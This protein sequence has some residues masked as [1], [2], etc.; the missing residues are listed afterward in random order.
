MKRLEEAY[1]DG[2]D[3]LN[4]LS[5]ET[6]ESC[7]TFLHIQKCIASS[8]DAI[9]DIVKHF[10]MTLE[11]LGKQIQRLRYEK[12]ILE[13][14]LPDYSGPVV[15]Q[16]IYDRQSVGGKADFATNWYLSEVSKY[17]TDEQGK[18]SGPN[19][20]AF[21]ESNPS[22]YPPNMGAFTDP[23]AITHRI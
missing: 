18:V 21:L 6:R 8:G 2:L 9:S 11:T 13:M 20:N 23:K 1:E 17:F 16:Y 3:S 7:N 12:S 19:M 14:Q 5:A 15:P 4:R 22:L 10:E